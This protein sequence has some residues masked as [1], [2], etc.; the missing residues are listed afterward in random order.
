MS[1]PVAFVTESVEVARLGHAKFMA[2][3]LRPAG[4]QPLL[5]LPELRFVE[6]GPDR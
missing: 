6:I 3:I 2:D 1:A 5:L 4:E